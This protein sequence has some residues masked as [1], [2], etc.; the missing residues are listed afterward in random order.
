MG[1]ARN[2]ACPPSPIRFPR[3]GKGCAQEIHFRDMAWGAGAEPDRDHFSLWF[4]DRIGEQEH[5][6]H[7]IRAP[8]GSPLPIQVYVGVTGSGKS[9]LRRRLGENLRDDGVPYLVRDLDPTAGGGALDDAALIARMLQAYRLEAPRTF[10]ALL[11]LAMHQSENDLKALWSELGTDTLG[12]AVDTFLQSLESFSAG[13]FLK[14]LGKYGLD[15]YR[16]SKDPINRYLKSEEGR[17]DQRQMATMDDG[18]LRTDLFRRFARDLDAAPL[19]PGRAA[20]AVLLID[21][22]DDAYR[23]E[24]SPDRRDASLAWISELYRRCCVQY[25]DVWRGRLLIVCFGQTAVPLSGVEGHVVQ[26]PLEGLSREHAVAYWHQRGL[27]ED[28]LVDALAEAREDGD[29]P[30]YHV[31]S[32]G[33]IGDMVTQDSGALAEKESR[34]GLEPERALTARF[35]RLLDDSDQLHMRQLALASWWDDEAAAWLFKLHGNYNATQ[36]KLRWLDGFSFVQSAGPGRRRLHAAMRRALAETSEPD[37]LAH[38][39]REWQSYWE[40]RSETETDDVS[41]QAWLHRF[42]VSPLPTMQAWREAAL[43]ALDSMRAADHAWYVEMAERFVHHGVPGIALTDADAAS[44]LAEWALVAQ[45]ARGGDVSGYVRQA[46]AAYRRALELR[47]REVAPREWAVVHVRLGAA[48]RYRGEVCHPADLREAIASYRL[49]LEVFSKETNPTEWATTQLNLG[50]ALRVLGTWGNPTALAESVAAHRL[51]SEVFTRD[52]S[53]EDWALC[54]HNLAVSLHNIGNCTD[55]SFLH[56]AVA[57]ERAA[58]EVWTREGTPFRWALAN[59]CL[60]ES[61]TALGERGDENGLQLALEAQ[62]NAL[63]VFTRESA[64]AYWS[65]AQTAYGHTL[66]L[67]AERGHPELLDEAVDL[68]RET[69]EARPLEAGPALWAESRHSL[70]LAL[71]AR[72]R[73]GNDQDLVES[74]SMLRAV[75]GVRSRMA[76]PMPWATTQL[77]LAE[78][79]LTQAS[80]RPGG[81][82]LA[83]ALAA[84]DDAEA[85]FAEA[86]VTSSQKTIERL[87][88][89]ALAE[90]PAD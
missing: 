54:M 62:R 20:Q 63:A 35:L 59:A 53:P 6:R 69:A 55:E 41:A 4:T 81:S 24:S 57:T 68:L 74:V 75:L 50:I 87:R 13:G 38:W 90:R 9:H 70:A 37:H 72:A 47:P 76:T 5:L 40:S 56:E 42:A 11:R 15:K 17:A 7:L 39:H 61:L 12:A 1:Q 64:P 73:R 71:L 46:I 49:A 84:L 8:E 14:T 58:L 36:A 82:D 65:M 33:L 89:D 60:S 77:A 29:E 30:R 3:R 85:G 78:A 34:A 48:L 27:A 32:L 86:G 25:G 31:F 2:R 83:E 66:C 10:T 23:R 79:L 22:F 45:Q 51:A 16:A 67:F 44:A 26:H 19:R 80:R 28:H 52:E 21:S 88:R 43:R 18:A